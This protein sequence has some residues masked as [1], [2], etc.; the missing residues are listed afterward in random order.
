MLLRYQSLVYRPDRCACRRKRSFRHA[1]C[2]APEPPPVSCPL[3]CS[4]QSRPAAAPGRRGRAPPSRSAVSQ[5]VTRYGIASTEE[6]LDLAAA[7]GK[8]GDDPTAFFAFAWVS[9]AGLVLGIP[10][11]PDQGGG[12]SATLR[13]YQLRPDRISMTGRLGLRL[14]L[15]QSIG[16]N[17]RGGSGSDHPAAVRRA[18]RPRKSLCPTSPL[19]LSCF[20]KRHRRR[21]GPRGGALQDP[22]KIGRAHQAPVRS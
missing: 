20:D 13:L 12:D 6:L 22:V 8:W 1:R 5:P 4:G 18:A 9:G 7:W 21:F 17:R 2:A 10:G 14:R 19:C 11:G 3:S 15:N 16:A